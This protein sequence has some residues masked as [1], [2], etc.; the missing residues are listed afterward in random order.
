MNIRRVLAVVVLLALVKSTAAFGDESPL[1]QNAALQYWKAFALL[2]D[3][4]QDQDMAIRE[5]LES[6]TIDQPARELV[7]ASKA[8]L[9]EMRKGA[10]MEACCWAVSAEEGPNASLPHLSKA[11]QIARIA[12]LQAQASFAGGDASAAIDDLGAVITLGRHCGKDAILISLFIDYAIEQMAINTIAANLPSL[13][14]QQLKALA[15]QLDSLPNLPTVADAVRAEKEMFAGWLVRA[16]SQPDGKEQLLTVLHGALP[17]ADDIVNRSREELLAAVKDV[18]GFYDRLAEVV[19]KSPEEVKQAEKQ[20]MAE[21][22]IEG[23]ARDMAMGLVPATG[24]ARMV[25]AK[26]QTRLALIQ[27]AVAV[28]LDG[29]DALKKEAHRDPFGSGAFTYAKRANGFELRSSFTDRQGEPVS[30][31]V[32]RP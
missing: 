14:Q 25:E 16:L 5:A 20:L 1:A 19:A 7:A 6:G 28:Q 29:P 12:C 21:P 30:M 18:Y 3:T 22:G 24:S 11:R 32:G 27:A 8:A 17:N 13:D 9:R 23:P 15:E 26:H 2:P 31:I 10:A 4:S